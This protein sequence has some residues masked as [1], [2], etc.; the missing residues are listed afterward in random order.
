[1]GSGPIRIIQLYSGHLGC[2]CKLVLSNERLDTIAEE[3]VDGD[4]PLFEDQRYW[5]DLQCTDATVTATLIA[6]GKIIRQ[7][8]S[9]GTH[10][11]LDTRSQAG[12][13]ALS[14]R[15]IRNSDEEHLT[16]NVEVL[17]AKFELALFRSMVDDVCKQALAL[18]LRLSASARIPLRVGEGLDSASA[19][20]RFFF[21]Q[22][23]LGSEQFEYALDRISRA[24]H[25]RIERTVV[26][27]NLMTSR[28]LGRTGVQAIASGRNRVLVP[29]G[30]P[31]AHLWSV[32]ATGI[33]ASATETND[34]PENRFI[35]FALEEFSNHLLLIKALCVQS[36][37][38][39]TQRIAD[40]ADKLHSRLLHTLEHPVLRDLSPS[41]LLPLGSP[42]LQRRAGYREVLEAWLKF[43]IAA[44]LQWDGG[45]D[46]FG[47]G[48]KDT[49]KLYEYWLFFQLLTLLS[50]DLGIQMPSPERFLAE[51]DD[52]LFFRLK[53]GKGFIHEGVVK[54]ASRMIS[55]KFSYNRT[56]SE[57]DDP[58]VEGSWTLAMRPDFTI[59]FWPAAISEELA[60]RLQLLVHLH[61]DSKYRLRGAS[62]LFQ[63]VDI[64][65]LKEEEKRG[66]YNRADILI[67]H[68]YR[69]AIRRSGGSYILYP[70]AEKSP[71]LRQQFH[72]I[73]PG[74]GAFP[75]R[76]TNDGFSTGIE[77]VGKLLRKVVSHL[78][79]CGSSREQV[80]A[81]VRNM[82]TSASSSR[83]KAPNGQEGQ[84]IKTF[85]DLTLVTAPEACFPLQW[86]EKNGLFALRISDEEGIPLVRGQPW[87]LCD[88]V[89]LFQLGQQVA[90]LV[91]I[92]PARLR[93]ASAAEIS[94]EHGP[95][96][97]GKY[98][99][100]AL[101][102]KDA[103]PLIFNSLGSIA[104]LQRFASDYLCACVPYD[105][106]IHFAQP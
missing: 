56:F 71:T 81:T 4:L 32:P 78:T 87:S 58:M 1:M 39:S 22:H 28:R 7:S 73:L 9:R 31:L 42:V 86:T 36:K 74:L 66:N 12:I 90:R 41:S 16:T 69:D 44:T 48:K 72:E 91:P 49:D 14:I 51:S 8:P 50:T 85:F 5:Y 89:L 18:A 55:V 76:P 30:H 65:E 93:V 64:G 47:A 54:A 61:F 43:H 11:I 21:L 99:L 19:P 35:R 88:A 98:A 67:A 13:L 59:S 34:T 92:N 38:Q 46:A 103:A 60:E 80:M 68:A 52:A 25:S 77:Q 33:V 75:V 15:L 6:D 101:N 3:S 23:L 40:A 62:N 83:S 57:N 53:A 100:L 24:P 94:T 2:G 70:G 104:E 63:P 105:A 96:P 37:V 26:K 106:L 79:D 97:A 45:D 29:V 95:I 82:Y 84:G 20:Q 27:Q 102:L 17:P 10:G